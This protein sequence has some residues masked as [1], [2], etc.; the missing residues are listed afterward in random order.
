[1]IARCRLPSKA[2]NASSPWRCSPPPWLSMAWCSRRFPPMWCRCSKAWGLPVPQ[3][4]TFAAL[5]GP[6][7]VASRIGD[8]AHGPPCQADAAR[9][10]RLRAAAVGTD[11]FRRRRLFHSCGTRLRPALWHVEW[12]RHH[13]QG[14][15]AAGPV[16][17]RA[18]M[19]RCWERWPPPT[20]SS[21]PWRPR[22]SPSCSTAPRRQ[23]GT[24]GRRWS[25]PLLS[26]RRHG[27]A[28][29]ALS[30]L[31]RRAPPAQNRHRP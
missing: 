13:R 10:H 28:G 25:S 20:S 17:Q 2:A 29:P 12:P 7:Q 21:M 5:I 18:A 30:P 14:C 16:R 8:I 19:A 9:R 22:C 27:C 3:A 15:R 4:V 26:S 6:A 24:D 23:T 1:M 31:S 11:D